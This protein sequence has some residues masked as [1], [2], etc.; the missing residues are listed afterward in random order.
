MAQTTVFAQYARPR[1]CRIDEMCRYSAI[2]VGLAAFMGLNF[3]E[4]IGSRFAGVSEKGIY[5]LVRWSILQGRPGK[6]GCSLNGI[7]HWIGQTRS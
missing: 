7:W 3:D 4:R 6:A 2:R 1:P 5:E